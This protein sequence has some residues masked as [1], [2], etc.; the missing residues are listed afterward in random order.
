MT[1]NGHH[2]F[3]RARKTCCEML[4]DRGYLLSD[5]EKSETFKTFQARFAQADYQLRDKCFHVL[6]SLYELDGLVCY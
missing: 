2:R 4:E 1:D 3:F 6:H 5:Q